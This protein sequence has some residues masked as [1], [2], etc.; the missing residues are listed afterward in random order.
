MS[1]YGDQ[2]IR[3]HETIRDREPIDGAALEGPPTVEVVVIGSSPG[4]PM[5]HVYLSLRHGAAGG[6]S[7]SIRL[8]PEGAWRLADVLKRAAAVR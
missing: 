5:P 4:D 8:S 1:T 7:T 6:P 2:A 3:V